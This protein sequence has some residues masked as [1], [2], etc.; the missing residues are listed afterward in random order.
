MT[1]PICEQCGAVV[2]DTLTHERWHRELEREL[3]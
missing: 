1:R 3:T 2:G